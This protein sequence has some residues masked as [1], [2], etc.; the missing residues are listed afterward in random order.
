MTRIFPPATDPSGSTAPRFA[1]SDLPVPMVYATYRIIRD[2]NDG[3]A[4]LFAGTRE[5]IV[6]RSFARLYPEIGDFI[7]RGE[8]WAANFAGHDVYYDERVMARFDGQRFWCRVHGR[9]L[10]S[11]DDPFAEAIYCFEPINRPAVQ[12]DRVLTERQR[13]ILAQ[14]AQGKTNAQIAAETGLSRRTVE[15]HR[16]RLMRAIGVS[17][18]AELMAW[19]IAT[20]R[21]GG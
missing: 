15:A 20:R 9:S 11:G 17:N 14:V 19:F 7:R 10:S 21:D 13:Q 12:P 1:L 2:C 3:F 18:G 8:Q 5:D 6:D 4:A 16:A